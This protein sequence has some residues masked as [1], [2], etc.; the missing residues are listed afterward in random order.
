MVELHEGFGGYEGLNP[1]RR[2]QKPEEVSLTR[3]QGRAAEAAPSSDMDKAGAFYGEVLLFVRDVLDKAAVGSDSSIIGDDI[4]NRT[5]AYCDFFRESLNFNDMVRLVLQHD[6]YEDCYIYSH[7]VNVCF[8]AVR[9]GLGLNFSNNVLQELIIAA[10]FHDIGMM[11][12]RKDIWNKEGRLSADEYT[13]VQKHPV[14]GEEIFK[15]I[16]GMSEVVPTVIGQHQERI[17]GSGYPRHL[18]KDGMHYLARL[19]ALVDSYVALTH[20]RLWRKR[21]LPDKAIQQILDNESGGYD[22]HFLKEILRSVSIFPVGSWVKL[23]SG[24][25]GSVVSTNENIPMRPLVRVIFDRGG[26]RLSAE[27][28]MDL[29]KQLLVHVE[30]CVEAEGL[31]EISS[32]K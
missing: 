20:T 13:E 27:R 30:N 29:S 15:R 25:I 31:E 19:L 10:L 12:V 21:F 4:L 28:M 14:Y 16:K 8:L 3:P 26:N 32:L 18:K 2:K 9:L 23:S 6:E 1:Q 22:P 7:S 17:D 11:K 24:E 5:K